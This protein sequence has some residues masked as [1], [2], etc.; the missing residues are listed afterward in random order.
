MLPAVFV[1]HICG[2]E[3]PPEEKENVTMALTRKLLKSFSLE[4]SAIDSIIE[5]HAETVDALKKERDEA[6]ARADQAN[7][8]DRQLKEANEKLAKAGDSAKI[9]KDFDDYKAGIEAEKTAAATRAHARELLEN[10]VG[11]KRKSA[12]DL[13]LAAENLDGY[14]KDENG[15]IKDPAAFTTA[16]KT[17]HAE[18]IGEATTTGTPPTTPPSGKNKMT[19]EEIEKIV[20]GDERRAAILQNMELFE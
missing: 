12:L 8:L 16:M 15:R 7:E 18:W 6:K 14:E 9:Q 1:Y 2:G 5:A 10:D 19:R 20:D 17:K 3:L 11:I 13:I 4:E